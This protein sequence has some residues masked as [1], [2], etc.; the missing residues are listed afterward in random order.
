MPGLFYIW[1]RAWFGEI[2]YIYEQVE[3]LQKKMPMAIWGV[4]PTTLSDTPD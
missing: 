2:V 3:I 1:R 4:Y